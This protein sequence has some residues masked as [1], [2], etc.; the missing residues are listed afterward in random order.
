MS[1][2]DDEFDAQLA[3]AGDDRAGMDDADLSPAD[4]L[5]DLE[6]DIEDDLE[7]D[8]YP[9]DATEDEID[10]VAALYREDGEPSGLALPVE[11]ANDLDALIDALRRVPGDAGAIGLVSIEDDFFVFV[12]VRGPL[13]QVLLSDSIA[14]NDWPIARDVADYLGAEIP[15]DEDD[16]EPIGDLDLFTDVGLPEIDL[17]AMCSDLDTEPLETVEGIVER[18]GFSA[19][20]DKVAGEFDL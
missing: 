20:Y 3:D 12:R 13:I 9:E 1:D 7:D 14:A 2:R 16:S 8:D 15:D 17:E 18:I 19:P 6:D 4:L 11:L 10:I 5:D